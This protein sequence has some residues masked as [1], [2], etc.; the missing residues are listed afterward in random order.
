MG[1]I[2][3]VKDFYFMSLHSKEKNCW[4]IITTDNQPDSF[5]KKE[6]ISLNFIFLTIPFAFW[7]EIVCYYMDPN[8]NFGEENS[9]IQFLLTATWQKQFCSGLLWHSPNCEGTKSRITWILEH[10]N[11]EWKVFCFSVAL[12]VAKGGN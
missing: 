1:F 10:G 2:I 9:F 8:K 7:E 4:S 11:N 6:K 3:P 5:K 12:Q